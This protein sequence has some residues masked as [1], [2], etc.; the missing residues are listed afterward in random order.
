MT[1][2]DLREVR[3]HYVT[4]RDLMIQ[5]TGGWDDIDSRTRVEGLCGEAIMMGSAD[6]VTALVIDL[7]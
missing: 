4:L 7:K 2:N 3:G 6:N 1:H 5:Q